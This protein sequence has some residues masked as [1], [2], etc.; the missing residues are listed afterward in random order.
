M[1]GCLAAANSTFACAPAACAIL[2]PHRQEF[3][4]VNPNAKGGRVGLFSVLSAPAPSLLSRG[5]CYSRRR[6][7]R[8]RGRCGKPFGRRGKPLAVCSPCVGVMCVLADAA[9]ATASGRRDMWLR[10][11]LHD[12]TA[13]TIATGGRPSM[14][15]WLRSVSSLTCSP[16]AGSTAQVCGARGGCVYTWLS[17]SLSH[18]WQGFV[19][20]VHCLE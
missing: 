19:T 17:H 4:F 14:Y 7:V 2:V 10:G 16:P 1:S 20:R 9:L 5:A 6:R 15:M 18:D 3:V 13:A 12:M 8:M 11:V